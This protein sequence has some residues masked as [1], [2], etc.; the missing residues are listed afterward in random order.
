M[1]TVKGST[2]NITP[3]RETISLIYNIDPDSKEIK[4]ME[5]ESIILYYVSDIQYT[6]LKRNLENS[7]GKELSFEEI[8][9]ILNRKSFHLSPEDLSLLNSEDYKRIKVDIHYLAK[10]NEL[11]QGLDCNEQIMELLKNIYAGRFESVLSFGIFLENIKRHQILVKLG[12]EEHLKSANKTLDERLER[13]R[14]QKKQ[15]SDSIIEMISATISKSR[16][17]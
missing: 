17:Q 9:A 5:R 15:S 11:Y 10:Y 7:L 2:T 1:K 16:V 12:I 13:Y 6:I 14:L 3:F 8:N 4:R